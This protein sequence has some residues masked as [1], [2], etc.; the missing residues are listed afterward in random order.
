MICPD[1]LDTIHP[2][3]S[4][5]AVQ[6]RHKVRTKKNI[7]QTRRTCGRRNSFACSVVKHRNR[8]PPADASVP[9]QG[10][11]KELLYPKLF[12]SI[13][14]WLQYGIFGKSVPS[15]SLNTYIHTFVH[16]V[17]ASKHKSILGSEQEYDGSTNLTITENQND[18]HC[19]FYRISDQRPL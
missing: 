17:M 14:F 7:T 6:V 16:F 9:E 19:I 3:G 11:F 18:F 4:N 15:L 5:A 8:L 12:L 13:L 1:P 2:N 10:A